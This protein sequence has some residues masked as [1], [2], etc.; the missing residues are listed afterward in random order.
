MDSWNGYFAKHG[1]AIKD[2]GNPTRDGVGVPSKGRAR[3]AVDVTGYSIVE[4]KD[5]GAAKGMMK[6]HPHLMDPTGKNSIDIFEI[7]PIM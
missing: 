7:T 6:D 2:G 4:A 1:P 3:K 5:L